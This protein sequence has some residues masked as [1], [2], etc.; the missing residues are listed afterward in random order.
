MNCAG[1]PA[2]WSMIKASTALHSKLNI[3]PVGGDV[4]ELTA[5][6]K[7]EATFHGKKFPIEIVACGKICS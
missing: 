2:V 5:G 4:L 3:P 7:C 1:G 6:V